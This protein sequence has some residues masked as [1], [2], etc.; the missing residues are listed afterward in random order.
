MY[1]VR[2][3]TVYT[4]IL[5]IIRIFTVCDQNSRLHAQCEN[6]SKIPEFSCYKLVKISGIYGINQTNKTLRTATVLWFLSL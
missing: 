2:T 1:K 3:R 6:S 4:S 5:Y